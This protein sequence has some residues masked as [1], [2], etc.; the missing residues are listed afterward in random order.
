MTTK[1]HVKF[2]KSAQECREILGVTKDSSHKEIKQA[3]RKLSL[4]YHP[5]KNTESNAS[6]KFKEITEAYQYL[7]SH[8]KSQSNKDEHVSGE[9]YQ[10][11]WKAQGE[12]MGDDMRFNLEEL[13]RE[14][15][16]FGGDYNQET[17][18]REK[19]I[20][21]KTT[22]LLLYGG[23]GVVTLWIILNEILHL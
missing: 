1:I 11:F 6:K 17:H 21:Q 9:D 4:K 20:S 13:R 14:N 3:Y 23:L 2:G 15:K 16:K 22:H 5:D 18:N 19:P 7:K 10:N 8:R 12:K